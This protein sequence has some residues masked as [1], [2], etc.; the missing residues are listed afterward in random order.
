MLEKFILFF[1]NLN[2]QPNSKYLLAVSGGLDSVVLCDL[3]AKA[4]FNFSIAH[5]NFGVR[6]EESDR[7]EKFVK[8]LGEKYGVEVF[9]KR[10]DTKKYAEE[11]KRSI[12]EAARELRYGWFEQ[13]RDEKNFEFTLLA[14][15]A[16][17]NI[18]TVLM[19][20]F[21]GTGLEGLTGM[22][23]FAA[24]GKCL[25]PM[26]SFTREQI[27]EFANENDLKWV[28]DSS[29]FSN[30]YTRNFFRHEIIPS[31]KTVYPQVEENVLNNI[32]RLNKT[33]LLYQ[34]LVVQLKEKLCKYEEGEIRIPVKELMKWKDTSFIYEL[35]KEYHF[36]EK[37]V[38]EVIKLAD[39]D[40]GKYI[41]N[42]M[43]QLIKHRNWFIIAPKFVAAETLA[44]EKNTQSI[45]SPVGN[46]EIKLIRKDKFE[47]DKSNL[48]AQV[49]SKHIEFPL[50]L[51]K[52]KQG[53]YFYP[54]GLRKKKKI[55]RFLIDQKL[56][57]NQ[58]EN[59]WV[60]ESG[61][62]IIWVVGHRIDDRF[63]ITEATKEVL[64]ISLTIL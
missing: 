11:N 4:G 45:C 41:E 52:W 14:H 18:E 44:F 21:R 40:S 57:K 26:L 50:L 3:C 38:E 32:E 54:L 55:A 30:K 13:I 39:A 43:Y 56:S 64:Q 53:D 58:K 27:E 28:E 10:F 31:I 62:R 24:Y 36:G 59:I 42:E 61:Q 29:N 9:V 19:N 17:D 6:G 46:F 34:T 20:F 16:N 47:L 23:V 25:R 37:Q 35:I 2:L 51:R 15:H 8:G 48:V 49:D 5:C 22:P 7:D 12:Q 63:K 33:N 1:K 60:M